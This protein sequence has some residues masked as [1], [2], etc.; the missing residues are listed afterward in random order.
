MQNFEQG[1]IL[2]F[3]LVFFSTQ[4]RGGE[5]AAAR[6][7]RSAR[8]ALQRYLLTPLSE[9]CLTFVK[10]RRPSGLRGIL[11]V[12]TATYG[13]YMFCYEENALTYIY[14]LD[15]IPG[16]TGVDYAA[17]GIYADLLGTVALLAGMP[18]L[19]NDEK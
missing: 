11:A 18:I 16:F 19:G 3:E 17:F 1:S 7:P 5:A 4:A 6:L 13:L 12:M 15:T 10:R 8:L 14:L 9:I 2:D